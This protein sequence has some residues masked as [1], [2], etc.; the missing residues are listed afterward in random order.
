MKSKLICDIRRLFSHKGRLILSLVVMTA[1][2][3]LT[4][5]ACNGISIVWKITAHPPFTP[6]L[7]ILVILNLVICV[8]YGILCACATVSNR[9]AADGCFR[10]ALSFALFLFWCPLALL[11]RVYILALFALVISAFYLILALRDIVCMR[12]LSRVLAAIILVIFVW[13]GYISIGLTLGL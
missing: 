6:P 2:G 7:F 11:A 12:I 8:L 4:L 13:L 5:F 10:V 9:F 1:I 3:I